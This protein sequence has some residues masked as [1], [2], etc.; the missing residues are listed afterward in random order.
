[1]AAYSITFQVG[2]GKYGARSNNGVS[3]VGCVWLRH[4]SCCGSIGQSSCSPTPEAAVLVVLGL[5]L[6]KPL[7]RRL[8]Q[9]YA[10]T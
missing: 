7:S 6:E 2:G 10:H 9:P 8:G 1:M 5:G 3:L 4:P